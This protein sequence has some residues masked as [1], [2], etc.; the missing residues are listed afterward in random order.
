[1]EKRQRENLKKLRAERDNAKVQN[2]LSELKKAAQ[3]STNMMPILVDAAKA[4]A[5][6]GE[7][8]NTLKE[9]YGEYVESTEF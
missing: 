7:M 9:V 6:V 3:G 1:M 4:Y 5:T 2:I 8:I